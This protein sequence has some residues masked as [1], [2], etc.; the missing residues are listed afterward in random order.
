MK[1]ILIFC[2]FFF[3][4]ELVINSNEER[5]PT[6]KLRDTNLN[7]SEFLVENCRDFICLLFK[8]RT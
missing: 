5:H 1:F 3:F 2:C 8:V 6:D 4:F 7:R